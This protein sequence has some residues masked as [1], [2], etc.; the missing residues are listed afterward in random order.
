MCV[1]IWKSLE[2]L[3]DY[4]DQQL[5]I[6]DPDDPDSPIVMGTIVRQPCYKMDLV[7]ETLMELMKDGR[8]GIFV[9]VIRGGFIRAGDTIQR[10][11]DEPFVPVVKEIIFDERY[12]TKP[13]NF[14]VKYQKPPV[15]PTPKK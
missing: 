2:I 7:F 15:A 14:G 12:A 1:Q 10:I 8:Q 4:L 11:S 13:R 9:R 3:I 6:G 5:I